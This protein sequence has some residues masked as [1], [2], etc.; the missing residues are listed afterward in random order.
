MGGT[1]AAAAPSARSR[2]DPAKRLVRQLGAGTVTNV[3]TQ[4][5]KIAQHPLLIRRLVSDAQVDQMANLAHAR[6]A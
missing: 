2:G 4:L 5:R 6:S 3:F 1:D